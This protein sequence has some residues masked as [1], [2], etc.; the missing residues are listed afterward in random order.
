MSHGSADLSSDFAFSVWTI[1][2]AGGSGLR[3]GSRKQFVDLQG[4]SVVQRSIDSAAAVS[5]GVIVVVPADSVNSVDLSANHAELLVVAG[6]ASRSE[7]VRAGL[8]MVPAVEDS[9]PPIVV[10]VHDAARPLASKELF[11]RV[12]E[13]V[14]NGAR[15][16]VPAVAVSDTIRHKDGGVLD[17]G[18]LLAVQTPQGFDLATLREAHASNHDATDDATLVEALGYEVAVVQGDAFNNK[19]T[20]PTDLLGAASIIEHLEREAQ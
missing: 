11:G 4:R 17:R 6:G 8:S 9:D 1:V 14:S 12:I 7:S 5:V 19:L 20:E 2:V 13:A 18:D 3:F 15:T 10:L 16:V